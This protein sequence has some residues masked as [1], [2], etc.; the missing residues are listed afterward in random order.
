MH[1]RKLSRRR[2]LRLIA[3]GSLA[4]GVIS[5]KPAFAQK[6]PKPD[7]KY[8]DTPKDGQKCAACVYFQAPN[9]CGV[10]EGTISPEGWCAMY[11]KK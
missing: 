10:V 11:N 1:E 8:Q 9:K 5:V 3:T 6:A 7:V 2:M 4:A